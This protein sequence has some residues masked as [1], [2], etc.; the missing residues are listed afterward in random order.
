MARN[1]GTALSAARS[2]QLGPFF[3]PA[4]G[5]CSL[6]FCASAASHMLSPV[7]AL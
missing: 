2:R 4:S 1:S 5:A 6:L 3:S 7:T